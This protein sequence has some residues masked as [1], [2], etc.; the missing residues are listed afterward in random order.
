M[1]DSILIIGGGIWYGISH[2][3]MPL[4]P[5]YAVYVKLGDVIIDPWFYKSII[6]TTYRILIG[7]AIG[8][9]SRSTL[10]FAD[11]LE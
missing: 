5:T 8:I 3:I 6:V 9:C 10:W 4:V 1:K 2:T 11:R 7:F